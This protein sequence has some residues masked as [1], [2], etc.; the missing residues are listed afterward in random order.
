MKRLLFITL[1]SVVMLASGF[2]LP[3]FAQEQQ[4]IP[5]LIDGLPVIFDVQPVIQNGRTLVPFR[6]TAEA[7]SVKV[8][9]D[10]S[11]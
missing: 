1:I 11:T 8:T 7:L 9:W 3:A 5:F 4:E 10:S 2:A 6:A